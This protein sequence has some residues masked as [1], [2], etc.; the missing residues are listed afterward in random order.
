M[1]HGS[2]QDIVLE[3]AIEP[4]RFDWVDRTGPLRLNRGNES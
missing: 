4:R 1:T 3:Y 2:C